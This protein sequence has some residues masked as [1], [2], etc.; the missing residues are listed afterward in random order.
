VAYVPQARAVHLEG[1][2]SENPRL[3]ALLAANRIRYHR[4]HH[5]PLSTALFRLGVIVGEGLR[6]FRGPPGHRAALRAALL[7]PSVVDVR[8][9]RQWGAA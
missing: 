1:E 3:S 8:L 5:G 7:L 4:R 9:R 2:Y 6:A